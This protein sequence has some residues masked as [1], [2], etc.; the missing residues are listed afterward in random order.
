MESFLLRMND[1][2]GYAFRAVLAPLAG[3][4]EGAVKLILVP[5]KKGGKGSISLDNFSSRFLGPNEASASYANSLLP[6][7]QTTIS[8]LSALPA[9][10]ELKYVTLDHA[11]MI[12]PDVTLDVSGNVTRAHPGF[13]LKPFDIASEST[14]LSTSLSWQWIRQRQENLVFRATLDGRNTASDLLNTPFTRDRI[15]AL[16]ATATYDAS[17]SWRGYSIASFI[18]S[19]GLDALGS[20]E[21]GDLNLSRAQATPDF[22]KAE[23]SLTRLQGIT[24]KWSL[25]MAAASQWA[26]GPL[27]SSEQFG[28]GGQAFGRAYDASESTGDKGVSGSLE[29]RYGGFGNWHS[30]SI[31]PYAFYDIG[32]VWNED[33]AQPGRES[34]ASAG[35]GFRASSTIGVLGNLGL[36]W[37]LTRDISTPIYDGDKHSPRLLAQMS[38]GF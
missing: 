23:L 15:R 30:V 37:P 35:L 16:R 18:V 22:T 7:T 13:T 34:G 21:K 33:S 14:F 12:A 3:A 20:S 11:I 26:S 29:L 25:L 1:L 9:A 6:L 24:G 27:Y 8:G 32:T 36:A 2:P 10:H 17:D 38:L 5:A 4:E 19:H 28:Y 31:T